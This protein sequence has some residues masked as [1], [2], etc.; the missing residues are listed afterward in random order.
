M[1]LTVVRSADFFACEQFY[2]FA[3]AHFLGAT[4]PKKSIKLVCLCNRC[5]QILDSLPQRGRGT[6]KRWMRRVCSRKTTNPCVILSGER[7]SES[8]F[9]GATRERRESAR[10]IAS[11][12]DLRWDVICFSKKSNICDKRRDRTRSQ[13]SAS[14]RSLV[15]LR[16]FFTP[17]N[18]DF[19]LRPPLKMTHRFM[20]FCK[21]PRWE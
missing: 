9:H 18:F 1:P 2:R 14:L 5:L 3:A 10:C 15:L 11:K 21:I 12:R 8:N 6:A 19:G 4:N 13:I 16:S 17:Q 7:S 20:V